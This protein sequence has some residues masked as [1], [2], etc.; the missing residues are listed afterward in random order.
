MCV[1][2]SGRRYKELIC[3][4]FGIRAVAECLGLKDLSAKVIGS[5][6]PKNVVKSFLNG[7]STVRSFQTVANLRK[8][9]LQE[10]T[11]IRF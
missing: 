9:R 8:K 5:T 1:A 11:Q 10:V 4:S 3:E 7:L 6:N 2:N